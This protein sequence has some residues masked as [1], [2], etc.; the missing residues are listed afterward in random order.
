MEKKLDKLVHSEPM[1]TSWL[2]QA[3]YEFIRISA[4]QGK[5]L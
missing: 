4:V 5:A 2:I 1:M 3:F